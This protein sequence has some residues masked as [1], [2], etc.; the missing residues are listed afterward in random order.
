MYKNKL[1]AL[2]IY[3]YL[4]MCQTFIQLEPTKYSFIYYTCQYIAWEQGKAE[5][6]WLI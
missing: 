3:L 4:N 5:P 1:A 2:P 6:G